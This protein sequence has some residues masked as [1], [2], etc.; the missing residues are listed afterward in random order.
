MVYQII[1]TFERI[2]GANSPHATCN[3]TTPAA[4]P[5][6]SSLIGAPSQTDPA[7]RAAEVAR[8]AA[9]NLS[10]HLHGYAA[11]ISMCACMHAMQQR[12]NMSAC[13]C[14]KGTTCLHAYAAK[15]Q[16]VCMYMWQRYNMSACICSK[17]TTCLHA[18]SIGR[19]SK[20]ACRQP[21]LDACPASCR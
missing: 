4:E 10:V 21:L 2:V 11:I 18:C 3:A 8:R 17:G 1:N 16:H 19:C 13:I 5:P 12:Y 20:Y 9:R 15:V 7:G 14:S 6:P